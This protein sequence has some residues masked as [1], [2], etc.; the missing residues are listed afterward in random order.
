MMLAPS[1][2]CASSR[3]RAHWGIRS[4]HARRLAEA[5][6]AIASATASGSAN[7]KSAHD[8]HQHPVPDMGTAARE[9]HGGGPAARNPKAKIRR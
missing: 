7:R 4:A 3:L 2:L 5:R 6:D 8:A 1:R 9:W